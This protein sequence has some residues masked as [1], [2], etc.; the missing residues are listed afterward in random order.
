MEGT[1]PV[2][3]IYD[4]H[5][6]APALKAVLDEIHRVHV[7]G[8]VVGGDILPGPFPGETIQLLRNLDIPA[9]FIHG[10]GDR[11]VLSQ[12]TGTESDW[13]RRAP[14]QQREPVRSCA[15]QLQA[16]DREMLAS[17]PTTLRLDLLG[18][19]R[20]TVLPRNAP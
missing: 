15:Q 14:E 7:D 16:E 18:P 13:Y 12:M 10:N 8:I 11:E 6:N 17:W 3:A 9:R 5:A 4:I 19:R 2:A 1:L 20:S